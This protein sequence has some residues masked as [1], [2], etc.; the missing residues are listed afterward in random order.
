MLRRSKREEEDGASSQATILSSASFLDLLLHLVWS[1]EFSISTP[2]T[3]KI[4]RL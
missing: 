1:R 3:K 4:K 2:A